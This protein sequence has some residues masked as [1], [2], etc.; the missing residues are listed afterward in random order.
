MRFGK[1]SEMQLRMVV[2]EGGLGI[3][4]WK[5]RRYEC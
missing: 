2:R 5:G 3:L 1:N 4:F